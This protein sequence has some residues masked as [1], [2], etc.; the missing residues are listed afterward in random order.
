MDR[1]HEELLEVVNAS[2]ARVAA[3]DKHG[4]RALFAAD[5]VVEDPVGT[6]PHRKGAGQRGS[7]EDDELG[8][9]WDVFIAPNTIR[10]EVIE[11]IVSTPWVVR[12]VLIHTQPSRGS[13]VQ[14]PAHLLYELTEERGEIKIRHLAAHWEIAGVSKQALSGGLSGL[15]ALTSQSWRMLKIQRLQ[16]ISGT[17]RG[18]VGGIGRQGHQRVLR[19]AQAINSLDD[20]ALTRLF[21]DGGERIAFPVGRTITPGRFLHEL[22]P[23]TRMAVS[24]PKAAGWFTSFR[25]EIHRSEAPTHGIGFLDFEHR[26]RRISRARFFVA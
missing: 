23:G 24:D 8:R 5:A 4:W 21:A 16:G 18:M 19:F 14:V 9:F 13:P 7:P 22:G 20:R 10:F 26:S 12:D 1:H 6:A 17:L 11:D 3:H 15:A 2:P 25:F